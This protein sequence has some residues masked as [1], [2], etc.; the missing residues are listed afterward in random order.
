MNKRQFVSVKNPI[1]LILGIMIISSTLLTTAFFLMRTSKS[2]EAINI[3]ETIGDNGRFGVLTERLGKKDTLTLSY[4]SI[5]G[6]QNNIELRGIKGQLK[7]KED[8]TSWEMQFPFAKKTNNNWILYGPLSLISIDN[9][10]NKLS[11]GHMNTKGQAL[12][13]YKN[14]WYGLSPII[15]NSLQGVGRGTWFLP[16]GWYKDSGGK[17]VVE[18]NPIRWVAQPNNHIISMDATKMWSA[19][20]FQEGHLENVT[21]TLIDGI[22]KTNVVNISKEFISWP[23]TVSFTR[24]DGWCGS[25]NSGTA[26]VSPKGNVT[27]IELTNFIAKK[28]ANNNID[29]IC[30]NLV[31][32]N[33]SGLILEGDVK[34]EQQ[35]N[36][37][38]VTLKA[39]IVFQRNKSGDSIPSY[40]PKGEIWAEPNAEL[41]WGNI[42]LSSP[43]IAVIR[44]THN[45]YMTAPIHGNW[46]ADCTFSSGCGHGNS[47]SGKFDGPIIANFG[48]GF[49][50]SG[51]SLLCTNRNNIILSGSPV[52]IERSC[53]NFSC[54]RLIRKDNILEF[55]ENVSAKLIAIDQNISINARNGIAKKSFI[56]FHGGVKCC[57]DNWKLIAERISIFL[58]DNHLVQQIKAEGCVSLFGQIED[59]RGNLFNGRVGESKGNAVM[60]DF[61]KKT[62]N[63]FGSVSAVIL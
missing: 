60:I 61:N 13:W 53:E 39:P 19:F 51:D 56:V 33:Q 44:R 55:P 63:W 14:V 12:S 1:W 10:N 24:D 41:Y 15:W 11:D 48:D 2:I 23:N 5:L 20:E 62:I 31:K 6:N 26:P 9:N 45:W 7:I 50:A 59:K 21:T 4:E 29:N 22:L 17:L 18:S 27:L 58:N 40:V 30:A 28:T 34:F 43:K 57:G 42:H 49:V 32:W 35:S 54:R 46:G 16:Q 37:D 8:L 25:A 3:V 47:N 36:N 52:I 38:L